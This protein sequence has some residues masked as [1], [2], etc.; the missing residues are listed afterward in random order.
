MCARAFFLFTPPPARVFL[1][2]ATARSLF[3]VDTHNARFSL[4]ASVRLSFSI[5]YARA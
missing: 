3:S 5:Y 4:G 2:S 1:F